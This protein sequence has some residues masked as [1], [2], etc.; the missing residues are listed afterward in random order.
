MAAPADV[1]DSV[2]ISGRSSLEEDTEEERQMR[3]YEYKEVSQLHSPRSREDELNYWGAQGWQFLASDRVA[4]EMLWL[5][6]REVE[7]EDVKQDGADLEKAE[8]DTRGKIDMVWDNIA[9]EFQ[10]NMETEGYIVTVLD[11][12][13]PIVKSPVHLYEW[14]GAVTDYINKKDAAGLISYLSNLNTTT[15]GLRDGAFIRTQE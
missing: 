11:N 14:S 5:F 8:Q 15:E 7:E 13:G 6:I 12:E 9:V 1:F 2:A 4:G 3:K 10:R